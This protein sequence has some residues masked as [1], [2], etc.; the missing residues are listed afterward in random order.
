MHALSIY[1]K[2]R[3]DFMIRMKHLILLAGACALATTANAQE[4]YRFGGG[5]SGGGWH[6]AISAGTQILNQKLKGKVNFQYSPSQGSVAN[7]RRV[8]QGEFAT[9]WGHIG[10]V[11]QSWNG[12]GLFDKDGSNKDFRIV[13]NVRAQTQ[14]IAVLADS[15]IKSFSDM[16]GKVVNLL[17]KGTG[18]HVN[19]R[20]I[21]TSLGLIDQIEARYTNFAK[22]AQALGDRQIDVFCSAGAPFTIPAL[23]QLSISKPV[24]Y[25]SM[26]AEEQKKV[27]ADNKFYVPITIPKQADVKGM[28]APADTIAYDVWWIAHKQMSDDSIY[29]MLKV[30]A[31]PDNLQQ[32]TKTARYW[33][34]LSGNFNA[35]K[36]H[37]IFVHPAAAKYWKERGIDVPTEVVKGY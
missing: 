30:I 35:L 23:T 28:D 8:G 17:A 19:C 26:T 36:E 29:N 1:S 9:A 2:I 20:N 14:I 34:D 22:A 4:R 25:I 16:K 10:Q 12:V 3:E 18:S 32:L 24:R 13:A 27:I 37:K 6:P 5:P 21:F 15:P 7:V 31:A 33:R 11:W